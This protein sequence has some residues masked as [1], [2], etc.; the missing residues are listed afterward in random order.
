VNSTRYMVMCRGD[1]GVRDDY[2]GSHTGHV[3]DVSGSII[4]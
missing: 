2:E 1:K 4:S 3:R